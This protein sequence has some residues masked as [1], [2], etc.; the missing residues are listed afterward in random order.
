MRRL[1]VGFL[2]FVVFL[3]AAIVLGGTIAG[4]MLAAE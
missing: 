3:G 4:L 1:L 2:W